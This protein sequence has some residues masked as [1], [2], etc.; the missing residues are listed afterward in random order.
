MNFKNNR[1]N[2]NPLQILVCWTQSKKVE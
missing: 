1:L 2:F